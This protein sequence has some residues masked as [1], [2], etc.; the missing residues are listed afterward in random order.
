MPK[1]FD[2]KF[3]IDGFTPETLPTARLAEYL[4][5]LAVMLG[6]TAK[7]HFVKIE[8]G[9]AVLVNRVEQFAV[10]AVEK[11]L[12]SISEGEGPPNAM[13][14]YRQINDRLKSDN[15]VGVL[16]R[17]RGPVIIDFPGRDRKEQVSYGPFSQDGSLDGKV[18]LVGG[19]SD[20]VPVHLEQGSQTYNCIAD[21]EIA[22]K[23]GT[24]LFTKE[25]RVHGVGRWYLHERGDWELKKFTIS[26]FDVLDDSGLRETIN[27][28][29]SVSGSGWK[30]MKDPWGEL[31]SMREESSEKH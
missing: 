20:P 17:V 30:D 12:T 2:Y 8:K 3:T 27:S 9:S 21:R 25:I 1:S 10:P 16:A 14:A 29:R 6:Q 11:Q 4:A 22:K 5:D 15:S 24:Y 7:V 13:K 31:L 19:S 18:I 26:R 28:L 23:L